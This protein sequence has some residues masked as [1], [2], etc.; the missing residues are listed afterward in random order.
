M[1]PLSDKLKDFQ[2]LDLSKKKTIFD[3]LVLS[4]PHSYFLNEFKKKFL[5]LLKPDGVF[6]DIKGKFRNDF[7]ENYWSL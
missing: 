2:N 5:P 4:V 1:I 6:F 3:S 7:S